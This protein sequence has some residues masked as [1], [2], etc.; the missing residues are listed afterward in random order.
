MPVQRGKA[1]VMIDAI[2]LPYAPR[3]PVEIFVAL[4]PQPVPGLAARIGVPIMRRNPTVVPVMHV[5]GLR[6]CCCA[7]A[8]CDAGLRISCGRAR[9]ARR[10]PAPAG[11]NIYLCPQKRVYDSIWLWHLLLLVLKRPV[12]CFGIRPS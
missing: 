3:G 11:G 8:L 10:H 12:Y 1:I 5:F 6:E 2:N 7:I 4:P 9:K